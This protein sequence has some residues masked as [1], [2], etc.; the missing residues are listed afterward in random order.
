VPPAEVDMQRHFQITPPSIHQMILTLEKRGLI[1]R[2][3]GRA[4]SIRLLLPREQLPKE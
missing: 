2:T 1:G 4:R 3:P